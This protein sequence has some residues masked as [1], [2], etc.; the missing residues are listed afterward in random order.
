[1][2]IL[3]ATDGS[4]FSKVAIDEACKLLLGHPES[5]VR[6][7]SAFDA[8]TAISAE[9]Y[10]GTAM[11]YQQFADS[12]KSVAESAAS[13]AALLIHN[14]C[15]RIKANVDVV[16][17]RPAE[18]ILDA[19]KRWS[20]DIIVVGSHGHGFWGRT[21]LGSVSNAIVH[22]AH[23]P[24]LVVRKNNDKDSKNNKRSNGNASK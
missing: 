6:I 16:M 2:K 5:S 11:M 19:A 13:D 24:V 7:I 4:E 9:P 10:V 17:G 14:Q 18:A 1:M 12:L 22:H 21:L 8:G 20:A 15:P 3:I 23:C